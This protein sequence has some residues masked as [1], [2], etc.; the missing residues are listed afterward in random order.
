MMIFLDVTLEA[1]D[2]SSDQLTALLRETMQASCAEPGCLIYR[3]SADLDDQSRFH[4]IE[5]WETEADF[6]AH[7]S[8]KPLARFRAELPACGKVASLVRRQ[9]DLV[10][11][12][13]QRAVP[14]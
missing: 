1:H 4:L 9:G 6:L 14:E 3:F 12:A 2:G 13:Y 11:Y 10:P 7:S 8:G 5:L